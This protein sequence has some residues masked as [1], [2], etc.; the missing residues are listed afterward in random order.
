MYQG[1]LPTTGLGGLVIAGHAF[2]VDTMVLGAVAIIG[3][4]VVAYR[5]GSRAVR[6]N[7]AAG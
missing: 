2:G 4:G 1:A 6:R 5:Y 3:I 7:R